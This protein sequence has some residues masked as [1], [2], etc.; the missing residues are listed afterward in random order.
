MIAKNAKKRAWSIIEHSR[1][2]HEIRVDAPSV[3]V[4]LT[5]DWHVDNPHCD[6]DT[7]RRHMRQACDEDA[8][9]V[10]IGDVFCAMQGKYDRRSS[11]SALRPEHRD[12]DYLDLLV[13]TTADFVSPFAG[14]LAIIGLGNHETSIID[15]HET[16]LTE[17]LAE[18]IR[19]DGGITRA[20]GY[21][22]WIIVS[23]KYTQTCR[24]DYAIYYHHG[25]G[26][27]GPVTRGVIDWSRYLMHADADCFVA[28]HVHY[29]NT[30]ILM[31]AEL[32]RSRQIRQKTVHFVRC[33]TY[34]EEYGDGH[35]GYHIEKGRGPRPIGGY[36]LSLSMS[37][38]ND[39]QKVVAQV[40]NTD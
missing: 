5:S 26:G 36:W 22:G 25:F 11:K 20:G 27:G 6:R 12:G 31:R 3:R 16:N 40:T 23:L 17:R 19:S 15:R 37:R 8:P 30:D 34:K 7:L 9:I 14:N 35:S 10:A 2:V 24:H 18:R 13:K 32:T 21:G 1:N 29:S 39:D 38:K 4:L 33:P 28:G